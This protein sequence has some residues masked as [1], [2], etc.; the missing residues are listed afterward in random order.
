[1][2]EKDFLKIGDFHVAFRAL[3]ENPGLDKSI[4]VREHI[5]ALAKQQGDHFYNQEGVHEDPIKLKS[6]SEYI[7][8][9]GLFS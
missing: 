5:N 1:M 6:P 7:Y 9:G 8:S 2:T 3:K 4:R